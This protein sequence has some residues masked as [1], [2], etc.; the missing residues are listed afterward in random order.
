MPPSSAKAWAELRAAGSQALQH[1]SIRQ[2]EACMQLDLQIARRLQARHPDYL[3]YS[4]DSLSGLEAIQ[5][6]SRQAL[7]YARQELAAAR[8]LPAAR[9]WKAQE[10]AAESLAR[11]EEIVGDYRRAAQYFGLAQTYMTAAMRDAAQDGP[12]KLHTAAE[13][14]GSIAGFLLD[15]G[16]KAAA[17]KLML[18]A[19][20]LYVRLKTLDAQQH[21]HFDSFGAA[22]SLEQLGLFELQNSQ[23]P[24]AGIALKAAL[25]LARQAIPPSDPALAGFLNGLAQYDLN[26]RHYVQAETLIR[27]AMRIHLAAFGPN[28]VLVSV[29]RFRLGSAAELSGDMPGADRQ[30]RLGLG[31]LTRKLRHDLAYMNEREQLRFLPQVG[32][33]FQ[34]YY[35]FAARYHAGPVP[36]EAY[37]LV[38]WQKGMVLNSV[39]G[40]RQRLFA[41]RDRQSRRLWQQLVAAHAQLSR[42]ELQP[43]ADT[44]RQRQLRSLRTEAH[45]LNARLLS[46][47]RRYRHARRRRLATWL[48]VRAA[49]RPREAAVELIRFPQTH[50][51]RLRRS[52]NIRNWLYAALVIT[53]H[54]PSPRWVDLGPVAGLDQ[55]A[56]RQFDRWRGAANAPAPAGGLGLYNV[57]WKPLVPALGRARSVFFSPTGLLDELPLGAIPAPGGGLL[58]ERYRLHIVTSTR[59][60]VGRRRSARPRNPHPRAVLVG[61]PRFLLAAN[62]WRL[63]VAGLRRPALVPAAS[64]RPVQLAMSFSP[65]QVSELRSSAVANCAPPPPRGGLT[66]P[67][68]GTRAEV[69]RLGRLLRR[70]GWR[71][72][73]YRGADALEESVKL[74]RHPYLLHL[75]THGFFF[76][77]TGR[78]QR[79]LEGYEPL[80]APSSPSAPLNPMLLSG[81]LFAGVDRLRQGRSPLPGLD[82]G[83]L[84]AQE[85]AGLDLQDTR[86]VT[87]SACETGLGR[88]SR[89]S[90]E[91]IF[92]LA[93][94]FEEAGAHAVLVSMWPV[95]DRWTRD[96]ML[97]FYRNWLLRHDSLSE[98]LRRAQLRLRRQV[99]R[100]HHGHDRP[101]DWAAWVL[102][103]Q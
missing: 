57:L 73:L 87:L 65:Q 2:A 45:A 48:Q 27:Q 84:T 66:C 60:L 74:A 51:L 12:D 32:G 6:H 26:R 29:D 63:A 20:R 94:G 85:A 47:S 16:D 43:G 97:A 77:H 49:L 19:V 35:S 61:A 44:A 33:A 39:E 11:E 68:P 31:L 23:L 99:M 15:I 59:V 21:I 8:L 72:Q 14:T 52:S 40:L 81:L 10:T 96:L 75:A 67:L 58:L 13:L 103:S 22:G 79:V 9:Y 3:V 30:Y 83:I 18:A 1:G 34:L 100:R 36:G 41:H 4:F 64:P 98:A 55:A 46:R 24:R 102:I 62:A 90:G 91:G 80:V 28:Y 69:T 50:K 71:V 7:L 82:D 53:P 92:G 76:R 42:L 88:I 86:L 95:P 54:S 5:G 56:A 70:A 78:M 25:G 17:E 89:E 101:R 38:L 93:R 37:N